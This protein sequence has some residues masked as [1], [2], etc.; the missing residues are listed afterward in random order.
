MDGKMSFEEFCGHKTRTELAFDAIDKNG[1]GF[2]SRSEF[3]KICP[4]MSE[5]QIDAAFKKFDQDGTGRI[6]YR[7]FCSMLNSKKK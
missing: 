6:N 2:V 5:E 1:D 3:R 4:N 7:E